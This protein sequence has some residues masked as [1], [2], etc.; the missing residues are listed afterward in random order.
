MEERFLVVVSAG[1]HIREG[2]ESQA[3]G[4]NQTPGIFV[5]LFLYRVLLLYSKF[6]QEILS[7]V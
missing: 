3:V 1:A 5:G 7:S 4:E 6:A 2:S